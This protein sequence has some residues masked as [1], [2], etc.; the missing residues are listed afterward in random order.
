MPMSTDASELPPPGARDLWLALT[1]SQLGA[2]HQ[3]TGLPNQDAVA[4]RQVRPD[5]LVAAV[6]DGH[7]HRRHFRS[8]RGSQLAVTVAC[9]AAQDLAARLDG[10]TT[11]APIESQALGTLVPAI[12]GAW[13][14]AVRQDVADDPFTSREDAVR[15][16]DDPLIAYGSTL[17][18]AIAGRRWLV[19]V[20]IGDGDILGIQPDGRALLPVPRD[21]SLD[22]HQTTSLCGAGAEDEFRAAVVDTSSTPLLGVMLATDGYSNAQLADPWTDAVS[23]DLAELI[24]DRPP[25]WLAGQLP[26][27]AGRCASADGSA[28]DTTIALLIAP[29]ATGWRHDVPDQL[30]AG[31][32]TTARRLAEPTT[33]PSPRRP[34]RAPADR[35]RRLMVI[36]AAVVVIAAVAAFLAIQLSSSPGAPIPGKTP[37]SCSS[38]SATARQHATASATTTAVPHIG[39][40]SNPCQG[41]TAGG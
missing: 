19:L 38:P 41:G 6:A 10:F 7:G 9:E 8:A 30:A 1:A 12:T 35:S 32:A 18:L 20:Q 3:A 5:V 11:A 22:G 34:V 39:A 40:V 25:E 17:L 29:S 33:Q 24:N 13:R 36:A 27:W 28:D 4:V 2:A 21:P 15:G 26:L 31:A 16:G 37:A 14:D 23:A